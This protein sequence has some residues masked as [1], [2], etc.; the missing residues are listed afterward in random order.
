M[1]FIEIIKSAIKSLLS[2]KIRSFLTMLGIMIGI[3]SV[4]IVAMVG[5]GSQDSI[6]G[7]LMELADT[8]FSISVQSDDEVLSKRDYFTVEDIND[9]NEIENITGVSPELRERVDLKIDE[10]SKPERSR[11]RTSSQNFLEITGA[12]LL[13]GRT[14]D[15]K[16][17]VES[18]KVILIDDVYSMRRFGRI[19]VAGEEL[20]IEIRKRGKKSETQ[21]YYIVG[22]YENP[23]KNLMSSFGGGREFYQPYVPYSTFIKYIDDSLISTITISV[24]DINLKDDSS[25]Q[26]ISF[27]ENRHKKDGIY[28]VGAKFSSLDSFNSILKN[29]SFLLTAVAGISLFVGGIGVMN[30]MLVSVT[31][32]I[33][34]IGIRKALGAK[35]SD[36]LFQFLTESIVLTI[37]GGGMGLIIGMIVSNLIGDMMNIKPIL[38]FHILILSL[39]VSGGIGIIFGTYPAKKASDLN[40]IDALRHE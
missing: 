2:N 22:V 6:T 12:K 32:R 15:K 13:Y 26:V 35:K 11:L 21:I 28:E 25:E 31:E 37:L 23:M 34:E 16:D 36:I 5:K 10:K 17:I 30:I 40:P 3:T 9:I 29:L 33:R 7:S 39:A 14:F 4:V 1:N 24:E 18:K 20:E 8:T 19:D 38:E 27:L